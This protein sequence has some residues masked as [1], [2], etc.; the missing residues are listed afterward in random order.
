MKRK[1]ILCRNK[2]LDQDECDLFKSRIC[3]AYP[4]I[5]LCSNVKVME[6]IKQDSELK[7]EGVFNGS[8]INEAS[9]KSHHKCK[10]GK[11]FNKSSS[12]FI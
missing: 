3:T 6:K 8:L 7:D 12:T 4:K 10:N 1:Y 9:Y 11:I 2:I 5:A